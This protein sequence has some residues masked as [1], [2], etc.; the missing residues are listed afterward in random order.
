MAKVSRGMMFGLEIA[1]ALGVPDP[2]HVTS[3]T[4]K[5]GA[6]GL[7]MLEVESIVVDEQEK[8]LLTLLSKYELVEKE[9]HVVSRL[10]IAGPADGCACAC[11]GRVVMHVVPCHSPL[12]QPGDDSLPR[13]YT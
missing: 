2:K 12:L 13:T 10:S 5:V 3:L 1:T 11:H 8:A 6:S 7:T 4:L 9:S